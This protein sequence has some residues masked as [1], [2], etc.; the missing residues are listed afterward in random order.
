MVN[1]NI[2]KPQKSLTIKLAKPNNTVVF[3]GTVLIC[4]SGGLPF[5]FS[6][7][8]LIRWGIPAVGI[9]FFFMG[10]LSDSKLFLDSLAIIAMAA[11]VNLYAY[12]NAYSVAYSFN[13]YFAKSL[14]CWL[15]IVIARYYS[16]YDDPSAKK[17]ITF[18]IL[19]LGVITA[20][21]TIIVLQSYPGAVRALGNGGKGLE[22]GMSVYL[23]SRNVSTWGLCYAICFLIPTM[24]AYY[25]KTK[26]KIVLVLLM[27]FEVFIISTEI[28]LAVLI[29]FVFIVFVLIKPIKPQNMIWI[30]I[31]I[32]TFYLVFS[33]YLASIVLALYNAISNI[34]GLTKLSQRI[35]QLYMTIYIGSAYGDVGARYDLYTTSLNTFIQ[36]PLFGFHDTSGMKYA[37]FGFHSQIFDMLA[38]VGV[39]GFLPIAIVFMKIIKHLYDRLTHEDERN[40]Y[41]ILVL[42][43]NLLMLLNPVYYSP[44]IFMTGILFPILM[45]E[46]VGQLEQNTF[47]NTRR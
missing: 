38:A 7:P 14:E 30:T 27:L 21:P 4:I 17:M 16:K 36:H 1:E 5:L 10:I 45:S 11:I 8:A 22:T 19:F 18:L 20:V 13:A 32:S 39:A 2:M 35:Y 26:K 37:N 41:F 42:L 33:N 31:A 6:L 23:Y 47:L 25:R 43:L 12:Y 15:F 46:N 3:I 24:S 44:S 29:S 40:Y 28:T 34:G 9:V